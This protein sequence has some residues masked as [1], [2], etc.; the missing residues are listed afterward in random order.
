MKIGKA[1]VPRTAICTSD[2]HT[3]VGTVVCTTLLNAPLQRIWYF[4][5]GQKLVLSPAGSQDVPVFGVPLPP[6]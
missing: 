3:I 1:T 2:A 6:A 4:S 5:V